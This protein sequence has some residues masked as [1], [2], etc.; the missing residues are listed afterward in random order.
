MNKT[1]N[2]AAAPAAA[3]NAGGGA[4]VAAGAIQG[5]HAAPAAAA[6]CSFILRL[7]ESMIKWLDWRTQPVRHNRW[8]SS[9]FVKHHPGIVP[10]VTDRLQTTL[11]HWPTLS[12]GRLPVQCTHVLELAG[13][14][15]AAGTISHSTRDGA[16]SAEC[17]TLQW[18]LRGCEAPPADRRDYNNR[19]RWALKG[20]PFTSPAGRD[21]N[22]SWWWSRWP[23]EAH[24]HAVCR[25]TTRSN[26]V[27]PEKGGYVTSLLQ[28]SPTSGEASEWSGVFF[29]SI[30][31]HTSQG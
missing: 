24:G 29:G 17:H 14:T 12:N 7:D 18:S 13:H 2:A 11:K 3:P 27:F 26:S 8:W 30:P 5:V 20:K 23:G 16:Q 31:H 4:P 1:S 28:P 15:R 9:M 21:L 25:V 22:L 6:V 19:S 10:V